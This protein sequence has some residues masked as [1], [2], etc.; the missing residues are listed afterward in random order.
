MT[1]NTTSLSLKRTRSFEIISTNKKSKLEKHDLKNNF[2]ENLMKDNLSEKEYNF[3]KNQE[4]FIQFLYILGKDLNRES[5]LNM[6]HK[7]FY[8]TYFGISFQ[9]LEML[10]LGIKNILI[11]K[12][13]GQIGDLLFS[14]SLNTEFDELFKVANISPIA[15]EDI[16]TMNLN[17]FFDYLMRKEYNEDFFPIERNE[18]Y[19]LQN[20][21]KTTLTRDEELRL[22][23]KRFN[24]DGL[25]FENAQNSFDIVILHKKQLLNINLYKSKINFIELG[26]FGSIKDSSFK[27]CEI[28][29]LNATETEL[30]DSE[31][32]HN[33]INVDWFS[34]RIGLN[35][36]TCSSYDSCCFS[37]CELKAGDLNLVENSKKLHNNMGS[38]YFKNCSFFGVKCQNVNIMN[39]LI[40]GCDFRNADLRGA[41]FKNCIFINCIFAGANLAGANFEGANLEGNDL[42][43][44]NFV[45]E[46]NPD[47]RCAGA[48]FKNAQ[49]DDDVA[50]SVQFNTDFLFNTKSEYIETMLDLYLNSQN[51]PLVILSEEDYLQTSD[52][53][54]NDH[55]L[56]L[57]TI[58]TAD[59]MYAKLKKNIILN[60]LKNLK[61]LWTDYS[62]LREILKNHLLIIAQ[63]ILQDDIFKLIMNDENIMEIIFKWLT[64]ICLSQNF[65]LK[66]KYSISFLTVMAK[67]FLQTAKKK[68][69][70]FNKYNFNL[71]V[72]LFSFEENL[73]I[74]NK[75]TD[76]IANITEKAW[77]IYS[78]LVIEYKK[79]INDNYKY[80]N[81][82]Y[83]PLHENI[84]FFAQKKENQLENKFTDLTFI[85]SFPYY[86][87]FV[88]HQPKLETPRN[89]FDLEEN[90][91]RSTNP[92]PYYTLNYNERLITDF[93]LF[94]NGE[95]KEIQNL[96]NLIHLAAIN[97][98]IL[99][100]IN[101]TKIDVLFNLLLSFIPIEEE[102]QDILNIINKMT[103]SRF[104]FYKDYLFE[105]LHYENKFINRDELYF[106]K[107]TKDGEL[108]PEFKLQLDDIIAKLQSTDSDIE[109]GYILASF[110]AIIFKLTSTS[111]FG[112]DSESPPYLRNIAQILLQQSMK[113][114]PKEFI[115]QHAND[116]MK[117][118]EGNAFSC[119]ALLSSMMIA[120]LRIKV[121]GVI[122]ITW[123]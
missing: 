83:F 73:N 82:Q 88:L 84:I 86:R 60:T 54:D 95:I 3:F 38:S 2:I 78:G 34:S 42:R 46:L 21:G 118:A 100:N 97:N 79:F 48:N 31:K 6:G 75:T 45:D 61:T 25:C 52:L 26:H 64:P 99:W 50:F 8:S 62:V 87:K 120:E 85:F 58:I 35:N 40:I 4:R 63:D 76:F 14:T 69:E 30:F 94:E 92:D 66:N 103:I 123:S 68:K 110:S 113:Y 80:I 115:L 77:F 72:L 32:N 117:R 59:N 44:V 47:F 9:K 43:K 22:Q 28:N 39:S 112:R 93:V 13:H 27:K 111:F 96:N 67:V 36:L 37:F 65:T 121:P 17:I 55:L 19:I 5:C 10:K 91:P 89:G 16:K 12:H 24:Y 114:L 11:E 116:W 20:F 41:S 119:S 106:N 107:L 51:N 109:K 18:E 81:L 7:I 53:F 105:E 71:N 29:S 104:L 70:I 33:F 98:A 102:K 1:T 15:L 56:V 122:P 23:K 90:N 57:S 74:N 101:K 108:H 49:F